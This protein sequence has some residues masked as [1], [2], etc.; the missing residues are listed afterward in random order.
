MIPSVTWV[1]SPSALPSLTN[2]LYHYGYRMAAAAP[3]ITSNIQ[4]RIKR[5][6]KRL[7]PCGTL[8]FIW[9][10]GFLW[11]TPILS[12]YPYLGHRPPPQAEKGFYYPEVNWNTISKKKNYGWGWLL[13]MPQMSV[14]QVLFHL[15]LTKVMFYSNRETEAQI[16]DLLKCTWGYIW[17]WTY[18]SSS[19]RD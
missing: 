19:L 16:C 3:G 11:Q 15:I 9:N 13:S 12:P 17:I 6:G 2:C 18:W 8:S 5:K 14:M 4:S 10:I 7:Y 1:L